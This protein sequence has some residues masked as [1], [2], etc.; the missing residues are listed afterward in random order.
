M[1]SL[2]FFASVRCVDAGVML[3][4]T[5]TTVA[6]GEWKAIDWMAAEHEEQQ[7]PGVCQGDSSGMSGISGNANQTV[8][9]SAAVWA[10][11]ILVPQPMPSNLLTLANAILPHCPVLDGLFKPS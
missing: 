9:H 4:K 3:R 7:R 1:F 2:F 6:I 5:P 10:L 11:E 8:N